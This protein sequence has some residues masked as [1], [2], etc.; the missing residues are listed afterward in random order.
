MGFMDEKRR[1]MPS[2]MRSDAGRKVCASFIDLTKGEMQAIEVK[3]KLLAEE[4]RV[5]SADLSIMKPVNCAW[6]E[7]KKIKHL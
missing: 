5:M 3:G 6:F 2:G 4:N 1:Q 7:N